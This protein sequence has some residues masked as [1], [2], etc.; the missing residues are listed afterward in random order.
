MLDRT[1]ETHEQMFHMIRYGSQ[2]LMCRGRA[3]VTRSFSRDGDPV[4]VRTEQLSRE[5]VGRG[6]A[7]SLKYNRF[8]T[9]TSELKLISP[10]H[11]LLSPS[12]IL[13]PQPCN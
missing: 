3:R 4:V 5:N 10:T 13:F 11:Q 8:R 12:L 9:Q 6:T 7:L 1:S 2:V